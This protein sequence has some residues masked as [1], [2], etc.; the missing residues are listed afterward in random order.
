MRTV[1]DNKYKRDT[2]MIIAYQLYILI[3]ILGQ[4]G[5]EMDNVLSTQ[6]RQRCRPTQIL[7]RNDADVIT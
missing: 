6:D 2:P 7:S 1:D 4:A 5:N 3:V